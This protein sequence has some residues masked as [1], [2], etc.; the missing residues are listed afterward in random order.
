MNDVQT[1][2]NQFS[3]KEM[4]IPSCMVS[5][6]KRYNG[7]ENREKEHK[8]LFFFFLSVVTRAME[9]DFLICL[10][11]ILYQCYVVVDG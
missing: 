8:L 3:W 2:Y 9:R 10:R 7:M 6:I 4:R 5:A 1:T 11:S